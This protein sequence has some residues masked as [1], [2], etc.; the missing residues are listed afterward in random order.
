MSD[1][2]ESHLEALFA[3][4]PEGDYTAMRQYLSDLSFRFRERVAH[5]LQVP[6]NEQTKQFGYDTLEKKKN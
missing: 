4:A 3:S 6:L 2:I 1:S 5:C